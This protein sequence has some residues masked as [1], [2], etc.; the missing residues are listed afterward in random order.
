MD[1]AALHLLDKRREL[2]V[3][4]LSLERA[5]RQLDGAADIAKYVVEA[6][7]DRLHGDVLN[8]AYDK[9]FA[10]MLPK[11]IRLG[12]E[13]R[14]GHGQSGIFSGSIAIA[15]LHAIE[16]RQREAANL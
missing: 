4:P 10:S 9:R 3:V 15:P 12:I 11:A 16:Q 14:G 2:L 5:G 8:A 6:G 1:L 7:D 13:R